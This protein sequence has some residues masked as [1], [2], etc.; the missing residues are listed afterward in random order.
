MF[1]GNAPDSC[2]YCKTFLM[3]IRLAGLIVSHTILSIEGALYYLPL[4]I[5]L[6]K[7]CGYL[8][9]TTHFSHFSVANV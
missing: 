4:C 9:T 2:Y 8:L 1:Y 5:T 3:L 7:T 6:W